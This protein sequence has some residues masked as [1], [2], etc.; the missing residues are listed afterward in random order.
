MR[1]TWFSALCLLA[2]AGC[3]TS[4]PPAPSYFTSLNLDETAH[5]ALLA[6]SD[7]AYNYRS[8]AQR[9]LNGDGFPE[10]ILTV[11]TYPDNV[12][13]PIVIIDGQGAIRNIAPT[14]FPGGV[15]A[16]S[17]SPQTMFA[18][19]DND[20]LTDIFFAEAGIDHPPWTG[21]L[22]GIAHNLGNGTYEDVSATVPAAA[23]GLR[24]Y[25]LTVGDLYGDGIERAVFPSQTQPD[26]TGL[27]S[28]Q[29]GA[30]VFDQNWIDQSLWWSPQNLNASSNMQVR[31]LD[32]DGHDDLYISGSWTT[33]NHQ[34][35][36]GGPGFPTAANLTQLPEGVF[37][38]TTWDEYSAAD[39]MMAEGADVDEV[40]IADFDGDGKLDIITISEDNQIF[41]P[42]VFTDTKYSG[43]ADI[44]ANG[45]TAYYHTA[46]QILHNNGDR[47]FADITS[48]TPESDLGMRYY[49]TLEAID[50]DLDGD[51]DLIG[52]YW[53]KT[54]DNTTAPLYG[55]TF[56]FNDGQGHFTRVEA[57]EM[58]PELLAAS[59]D[60]SSIGLGAFFPRQ[61]TSTGVEGFFS[62]VSGSATSQELRVLRFSASGAFHLP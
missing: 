52:H 54:Y 4:E 1:C 60:T 44:H 36:F 42:G 18:D 19:Y 26:Q 57:T 25:S 37:G 50:L 21:K 34:I 62:A 51:L 12:Q 3:G 58:F 56:F 5:V 39:V 46:L 31:D 6:T 49:N 13:Q 61:I 22:V 20:G 14:L 47:T 48:D 8:S 27:L 15:P 7:T 59:P 55:T 33:P 43:Y 24:C 45:G 29:N 40:A 23:K 30:F 35:M 10:S 38:H 2:A 16:L 9:D 28:W 41:K 17:H 32:G 53:S 11:A